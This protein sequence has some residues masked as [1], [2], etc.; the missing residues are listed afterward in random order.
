MM[1][2]TDE[3]TERCA[4][5]PVELEAAIKAIVQSEFGKEAPVTAFPDNIESHKMLGNA[6]ILLGYR[7]GSF[8]MPKLGTQA[9]MRNISFELVVISRSM[10]GH[11][12]AMELLERLRLALQGKKLKGI[13]SP[14]RISKDTFMGRTVGQWWYSLEIILIGVPAFARPPEADKPISHI[15]AR[16]AYTN[17]IILDEVKQ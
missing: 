1:A 7:G 14:I 15:I 11:S 4:V 6:E 10:S 12:G 16:D 5:T 9:Q 13:M 17:E 3:K 2:A 8:D